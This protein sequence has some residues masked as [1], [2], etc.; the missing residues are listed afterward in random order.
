MATTIQ[1]LHSLTAGNQPGDL[2]P[3]EVAYNLADGFVYLGSGGN[4]YVDT[5]G[6]VIGTA[7]AEGGGWQQAVF[8]ASPVNGSVTLAGIY[9]AQD[10]LVTAVTTAGT[11]AG[12][13]AGD[14]LPAAAVG[15]TDYYVLVQI[16]GTL[17]PPAPTGDAAPGD[18]LVSTGTGWALVETSNTLIPATNV[19]IT[20]TGD[21]TGPTMQD[22]LN[23]IQLLYVTQADG[24]MSQLNCNGDAQVFGS[25]T[26]GDADTDALTV[27]A[28][29]AFAAPVSMAQTLNVTGQIS[30]G[31]GCFV[32]GNLRCTNNLIVDNNTT[33]GNSATD[34]VAITGPATLQN[35]LTVAGVTQLNGSTQINGDLTTTNT[36]SLTGTGGVTLSTPLSTS[37][38]IDVSIGGSADLS[39]NSTNVNFYGGSVTNWRGQLNLTQG[40]GTATVN[41]T[42]PT[43]TGGTPTQGNLNEFLVV[44][45]T[46]IAFGG[47]TAPAGYLP[48]DGSYVSQAQ[49]ADL[50]AVL[51]TTWGVAPGANF[52]LPDLRGMFLRGTGTNNSQNTSN[53]TPATGPAVGTKVV[54]TYRKHNHSLLNADGSKLSSNWRNLSDSINQG[55]SSGLTSGGNVNFGS[56]VVSTEGQNETQPVNAG[57][58]Y[59]I[60]F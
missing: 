44:P 53:N 45:G 12:F 16:G 57:V 5:L 27:N 32:T 47:T 58:L 56:T 1:N 19:E 18:W 17:T 13:T 29:S 33:L 41:Y 60:K 42:R 26:L 51:G 21:F 54:D 4:N 48:C 34:T 2:L 59:C 25:T 40:S 7:T 23:Q 24:A 37:G 20:P 38:N 46:I 50:Y 3:G 43:T 52:R 10:N 28:T 36:V 9:D 55:G 49:Y 6:Q 35:N 11:A 30:A 14:P 39:I 8:N 22:V 15:N 31:N